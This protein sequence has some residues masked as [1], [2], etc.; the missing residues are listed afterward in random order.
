LGFK[1]QFGEPILAAF[2]AFDAWAG[3]LFLAAGALETIRPGHET[4]F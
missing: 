3:Q 2:A 1:S 4:I